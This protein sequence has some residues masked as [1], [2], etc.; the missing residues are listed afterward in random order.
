MT[1]R[2]QAGRSMRDNW[3]QMAM[4][5]DPV[6]LILAIEAEAFSKGRS[7]SLAPFDPDWA[8]AAAP[9]LDVSTVRRWL[10]EW[11]PHDPVPDRVASRYDVCTESKPC[12]PHSFFAE[13]TR[14]SAAPAEEP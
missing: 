12:E 8:E 1:P 11:Q 13:Y 2:T 3:K 14:L 9:A 4:V 10:D 6:N 7:D 5:A